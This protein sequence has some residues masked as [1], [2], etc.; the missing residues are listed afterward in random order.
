MQVLNY[1]MNVYVKLSY[2]SSKN[3]VEIFLALHIL[4]I[5]K[6]YFNQKVNF[7]GRNTIMT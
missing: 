4:L 7:I 1:T 2:G 6:L 3:G 5:K